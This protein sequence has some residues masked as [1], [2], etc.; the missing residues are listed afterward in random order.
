[1]GLIKKKSG[2]ME[3]GKPTGGWFMAVFFL[4]FDENIKLTCVSRSLR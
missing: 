4:D 3:I 1:M 2:N